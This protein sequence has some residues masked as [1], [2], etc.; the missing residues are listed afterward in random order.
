MPGMNDINKRI[1]DTLN[2]LDGI[3]RAEANPFLYTRVQ[4]KLIRPKG[5]LEKLAVIAGKPAFAILLL[6]IVLTTNLM[7]M[8]RGSAAA[9]AVKQ[10]QTQFAV[11]D[12]YHLDVPALYD[13]ENPEP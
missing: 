6:A 3:Q 9:S 12:E 2:S 11:A 1:E 8:L 7:V 4:A 5:N 13:Y 10:E